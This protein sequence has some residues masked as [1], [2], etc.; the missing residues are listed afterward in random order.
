LSPL[1]GLT[2]LGFNGCDLADD[3]AGSVALMSLTRLVSLQLTW[4]STGMLLLPAL[5]LESFQSL[6]MNGVD[7]DVSVLGRATGLTHLE[8]DCW[9]SESLLGLEPAIVKMSQLRSLSLGISG[10][11][12]AP[13]AFHLSTVLRALPSLTKFRY[14]GD[15]RE[16]T[17]M[18]AIA[19]VSG[20]LSL[21]LKTPK[22]TRACLPALQAMSGLTQLILSHTKIRLEHLTPEVRA[23]FDLERDRRGWPRLKIK[24]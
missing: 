22:V 15:F 18:T 2:C 13:D 23:V 5:K 12:Q 6:V 7:G 14:Q 4:V 20:L 19:A 3:V 21:E 11:S 17:D 16:V 9:R 1:T 10:S 8:F 24:C